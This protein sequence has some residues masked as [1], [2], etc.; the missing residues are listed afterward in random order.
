M[1]PIW[2]CEQNTIDSRRQGGHS[3]SSFFSLRVADCCFIIVWDIRHYHSMDEFSHYDLLDANT[4][5]RV[6]EGHKASFCLEDTSCDYG[7]HRR[8]ACTAHTQVGWR[9][10]IRNPQISRDDKDKVFAYFLPP[11]IILFSILCFI[12]RLSYPRGKQL[13]KGKGLG[14]ANCFSSG[15]SCACSPCWWSQK[16]NVDPCYTKESSLLSESIGTT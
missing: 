8:F 9:L 15:S 1:L 11:P 5:R 16:V 3:L 10:D 12:L 14:G 7:Y 2:I 4:Q 13:G 6:A